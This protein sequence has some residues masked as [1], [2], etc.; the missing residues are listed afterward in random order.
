MRGITG[1]LWETSLLDAEEGIRFRGHT[2]PDLQQKLPAAIEGGEPLPEGI[3]WLM[4]T[5]EIPTE[6]QVKGLSQEL[7]SR[8]EL[9][10]QVLKVLEALPAN[11]HPM[12]Q[13]TCAIMAMQ[14][15][16]K[17]AAAYQAGV[18][19]TKIWEHAFEVMR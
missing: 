1:M 10:A 16:S 19:K 4:L 14:T 7:R 8:A 12:T 5:G 11:T 13:L 15:E 2:I 3:L 18:H 6:A 9:P 17:F